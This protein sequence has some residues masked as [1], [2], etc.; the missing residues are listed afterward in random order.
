MA[1]EQ[2]ANVLASAFGF[3][4]SVASVTSALLFVRFLLLLLSVCKKPTNNNKKVTLN[5]CD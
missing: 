3:G 2:V 5:D 1:S 4:A